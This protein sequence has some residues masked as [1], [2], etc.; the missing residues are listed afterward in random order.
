M[1]IL[2]RLRRSHRNEEPEREEEAPPLQGEPSQVAI[3]FNP[4]RDK[5]LYWLTEDG[6]I[7]AQDV[8]CQYEYVQ[9]TP[10][11][12][13]GGQMKVIAHLNRGG[14]GLSELVAFCESCRKRNSTIFDIS[15]DVYQKWWGEQLGA[16]YIKQFD[17][18]PRTPWNPQ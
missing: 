18:P 11:V 2:R 17:G 1:G 4:R 8:S 5:Y 6:Y 9:E 7:I 16:L 3:G 13:C 12:H 15:N 14:Q 10:C